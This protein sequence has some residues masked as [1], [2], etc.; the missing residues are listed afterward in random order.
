[1]MVNQLRQR[2]AIKRSL[3]AM[4]NVA[5]NYTT[6]FHQMKHDSHSFRYLSNYAYDQMCCLKQVSQ[7]LTSVCLLLALEHSDIQNLSLLMRLRDVNKKYL[8]VPDSTTRR[9][10][11]PG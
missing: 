3:V 7:H 9:D 5:V 8:F 2:N 1:M 11:E 10:L 6:R 4:Y